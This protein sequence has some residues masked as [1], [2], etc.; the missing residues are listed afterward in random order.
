MTDFD[1][2]RSFGFVLYETARLLS[3]RFDQR[4]KCL[5]LTRAQCQGLAYLVYHEG[6]NQARLAELLELEPISVARLIDRMAQAGWVERR[7]DPQDRRAWQ[8]FITDKA[9]PLFAEMI[10]VGREV[11]AEALDGFTPAESDQ[12]MELLLRARRN[13]S[14]N[15]AEPVE[16][17]RLEGAAE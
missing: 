6:I 16:T 3:K 8:L 1:F 15:A 5:G 17:V 4:S 13:L 9:K 14:E 12:I 2:N 7:P 10:A 11:R